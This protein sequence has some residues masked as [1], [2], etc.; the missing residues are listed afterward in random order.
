MTRSLLLLLLAALPT[1]FLAGCKSVDKVLFQPTPAALADRLPSLEV[2]VDNG[3]LA[4][5]D[6]AW[7][8]DP[9]KLFEREVRMN[10]TEPEDTLRYGYAKLLITEVSTDRQGKV[11]QALQLITLMTPS[12]LGVPLEWYH[13][14]LKAEMQIVDARGEVLGTYTG[15]GE[16]RIK[17]AMYH[18]YSQTQAPRLADV[19]ALRLALAQIKPQ[20]SLDAARL[21]DQLLAAGPVAPVAEPAED[22]DQD[23][24]P[25]TTSAETRL[26][27]E[28]ASSEK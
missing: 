21:R 22:A 5:S 12:V 7:P 8:D 25:S 2:T 27:G 14:T 17:V 24:E 15:T 16:S 19:E 11:L 3:P 28:P 1:W 20:V 9:Q 26:L 18:G 23:D 13:T 10:M 6:G 4:Q